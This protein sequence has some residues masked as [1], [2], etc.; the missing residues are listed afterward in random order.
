M[1]GLTARLSLDLLKLSPGQVIAVTG[2]AGA[3]GGYVIQLAKATSLRSSPMLPKST[4]LVA[5]LGDDIVVSRGDDVA[6]RICSHF[7]QGVDGLAD[8]AVLIERVISAVRDGGRFHVCPRIPSYP[9]AGYP[10]HGNLCAFLRQELRSSIG[11]DKRSR[12]ATSR[13]AWQMSIRRPLSRKI[14]LPRKRVRP[15]APVSFSLTP[16]LGILY[17]PRR[18]AF[19]TANFLASSLR[20]CP[21]RVD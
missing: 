17:A 20:R 14:F 2:A 7:P 13:F 9:A 5:S 12:P 10:L 11:S 8:G 21:L 15:D 6:S 16:A 19:A 4:K 18:A 1:N 3:Y